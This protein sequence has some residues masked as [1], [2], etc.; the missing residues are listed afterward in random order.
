[1][2]IRLVKMRFRPEAVPLF[3]ALFAQT[4]PSIRAFPGCERLELWKG[5]DE[6]AVYFTC[7]HWRTASDLEAY[8]LSPLFSATWAQTKQWFDDKPQ[9][10]STQS[11]VKLE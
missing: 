9:A 7:S 5:E 8:R 11:R 3:E 4:A 10:W 2:I 6:P 1:M